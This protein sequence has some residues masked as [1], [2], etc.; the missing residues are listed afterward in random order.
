MKKNFTG[1]AWLLLVAGLF[2]GV[3][4]WWVN[5]SVTTLEWPLIL[6]AEG[7][8]YGLIR[9][10][11]KAELLSWTHAVISCF[12]FLLID[13]VFLLTIL[14]SSLVEGMHSKQGRIVVA[15]M[16]WALIIL[17]HAALVQVLILAF[18]KPGPTAKEKDGQ[19]NILDDVVL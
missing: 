7:L 3:F 1:P 15:V 9:R 17:A 11:N 13:A 10:R 2:Q 19:E 14:H 4:A 18:R 5:R 16:F 8:V 6:L 12:A